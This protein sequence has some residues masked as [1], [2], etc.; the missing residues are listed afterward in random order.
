MKLR[1][2]QLRKDSTMEESFESMHCIVFMLQGIGTCKS[3][4]NK[5]YTLRER[6]MVFRPMSTCF[7]CR[8]EKDA[9]VMMVSFSD[10]TDHTS[11]TFVNTLRPPVHA[12]KANGNR[13]PLIDSP[14]CTHSH[15]HTDFAP[16]IL[17]IKPILDGFFGFI[18]L[19]HDT[20]WL[21]D[22]V[23]MERIMG[24]IFYLYNTVYTPAENSLFFAPL[25]SSQYNFRNKVLRYHL[26]AKNVQELANLCGYTY[27]TF[28]RM[29]LK[30]FQEA[31]YKWM[32]EER[33]KRILKQ[34][35][36]PTIPIKS[37]ASTFYFSSPAHLSKFC[38]E[39]FNHTATEIR[40]KRIEN[41]A[42]QVG[43]TSEGVEEKEKF[44]SSHIKGAK[45]N[46]RPG[47]DLRAMLATLKFERYN[48]G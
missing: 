35:E 20:P 48:K 30:Q 44:N 12:A 19:I 9:K 17:E 10:V 41:G 4:V 2:L 36:D 16:Y 47:E 14:P 5:E 18:G 8:L 26:Q 46:F 27:Y 34:L 45:I 7:S 3:H 31:P 25:I 28:N 6:E 29:F 24:G 11:V 43:I 40:Q 1:Y 37:I 21:Q 32:I 23:M 22:P 39:H 15:A 42:F 13:D 38:K 33:K